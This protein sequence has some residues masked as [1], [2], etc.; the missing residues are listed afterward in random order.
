MTKSYT[1]A[2]YLNKVLLGKND[3]HNPFVNTVVSL[4]RWDMIK[5]FIH[6]GVTV[7]FRMTGDEET[8]LLHS[9]W[10]KPE[11]EE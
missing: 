1:L 5:G 7:N 8:M 10:K 9:E 3:Y 11:D 2:I 6:G 4:N